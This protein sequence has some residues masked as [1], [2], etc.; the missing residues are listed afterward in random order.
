MHNIPVLF[1]LSIYF[2]VLIIFS[3]SKTYLIVIH[4]MHLDNFTFLF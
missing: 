4:L 2:F 3:Y 1:T